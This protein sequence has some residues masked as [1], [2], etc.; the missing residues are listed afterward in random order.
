MWLLGND[1]SPGGG[2][3][4]SGTVA[5]SCWHGL[6]SST[7]DLSTELTRYA[8]TTTSGEASTRAITTESAAR[9]RH[10]AH[11]ISSANTARPR[12]DHCLT[13]SSN[14]CGADAAHPVTRV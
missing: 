3:A 10:Q 8:T 14:Q 9:A 7:S 2:Q 1:Q 6:T 12:A 5:G 4:S 13:S 11:S